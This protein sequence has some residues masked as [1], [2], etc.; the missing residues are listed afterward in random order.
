MRG[1]SPALTPSADAAG[2][3]SFRYEI[4]EG[5]PPSHALVS[6]TAAIAGAAPTEIDPLGRH[7]DL[8]AL[9]ALLASSGERT[10]F[11]SSVVLTADGLSLT[12]DGEA[13]VGVARR[14]LAEWSQG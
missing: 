14:D 6:V 2:T 3:V 9:D 4:D 5:E 10:A 1:E 12:I 13:I 8:E 7:V 11:S